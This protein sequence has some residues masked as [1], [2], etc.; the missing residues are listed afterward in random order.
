M[1]TLD[2]EED[3][4]FLGKHFFL[5]RLYESAGDILNLMVQHLEHAD[6]VDNIPVA[7]AYV[8]TGQVR[9]KAKHSKTTSNR[10]IEET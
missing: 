8:G 9:M 2:L 5:L 7:Y 6:D 3:D 1:A 10:L 4:E